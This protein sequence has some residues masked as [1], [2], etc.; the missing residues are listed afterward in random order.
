[1]S[2]Q[3]WLPLIND[4][5]NYGL[6]KLQIASVQSGCAQS[7]DGKLGKCWKNT[8]TNANVAIPLTFNADQF[9]LCAWVRIDTKRS[10]WC[11]AIGLYGANNA[12][13]I[14]LACESTNATT[15]GF[16]YY[17]TIDGT[18]TRIFDNYPCN[19]E[20]GTWVHYAMIYDGTKYYIYKNGSVLVSGNADRAN[21]KAEMTN[22]YLFG[23]TP[24][25]AS[26]C[27][28]N[29]VRLYNHAL[30]P[31]EVKEISKGLVCH[32]PLDNNGSGM[33]NLVNGSNTNSI[34]TNGFGYSEQTGGSTRTIE[35]DGGIPCVK[36]TRNSTAHSGW[37]YFWYNKLQVSNLKINTTYTIS[38]DAIG[39]GSGTIGLSG[40]LQDNGTNSLT[41]S[42]TTVSNSFNSNG[43]SHIH[44][45][46][47][48]KASFDGISVS[49]QVV[50]MSC[51]FLRTVS[52]WIKLKNIRVTE[53][54]NESPW[55]PSVSDASYSIFNINSNKEIDISGYKHDGSIT[56]KASVTS[57]TPKYTCSYIFNGVVN[58]AIINSTTDLNYTDNFS[59]ACWVK[60][61]YTG[62][63][64]QYA[65]TV[66][67]ADAGGYGYGLRCASTTTCDIRFGN[68]SYSIAITGGTWAH[69][70]FTKNGTAIKIYKN[71]ELANSYTF[72]GT[73]P[74]YSDGAGVGIGCFH[75]ASGNIYPYYGSIS[76]FRIYATALSADD[77]KQLYQVSASIDNNGNV[78]ASDIQE[79]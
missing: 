21:I 63:T 11:R 49:G 23:G 76:D 48:T 53:G 40:F 34:D 67:R 18:N 7:S 44:F 77:I 74:T 32:Y 24:G 13:Y 43:W 50:Y 73:L 65:W 10:N 54:S 28:L 69:L 42:V 38:F 30:S 35:Y 8:G 9:S 56:T 39:S 78:F 62:T 15:I 61:N 66:G 17:K 26:L 27:S 31:K 3:V 1:M 29:D 72:D 51:A 2:L 37:D 64:A 68:K 25:N 36:I 57:D 55:S 6:N 52:T 33:P 22:L 70:A 20:I 4:L 19:V 5:Y 75:Y 41:Q 46:T 60:T 16:H 45:I 58:N 79:V 47:T 14:G 59:W 71:G 12:M